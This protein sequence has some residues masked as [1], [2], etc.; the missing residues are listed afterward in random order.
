MRRTLAVVFALAVVVF[1]APVAR[2]DTHGGIAP[3]QGH[4]DKVEVCHV[5][6]GNPDA[7]HLI[8][9]GAPAVPAH[10]AHG[11]TESCDDDE[12]PE[13]GDEE[14]PGS[15]PDDGTPAQPPG[16]APSAVAA[17]PAYWLWLLLVAIVGGAVATALVLR[18]R[19]MRAR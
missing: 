16:P 4:E 13:D 8:T 10:M 19:R 9:V 12:S 11:D 3:Y 15:G 6:P 1:F 18:R 5:P 17:S 2:A 14:N 7:A